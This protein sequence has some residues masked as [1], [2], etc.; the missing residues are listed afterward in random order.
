MCLSVIIGKKGYLY[1]LA[2]EKNNSFNY[3]FRDE[4][5]KITKY[6]L[7]EEPKLTKQNLYKY[8]EILKNGYIYIVSKS[9]NYINYALFDQEPKEYPEKYITILNESF[10]FGKLKF[11]EY[12][13]S[14]S[15]IINSNGNE[16]L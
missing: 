7:I 1:P 10:V 2:D 5:E 13:E 3:E 16:Y 6:I 14:V 11:D 8:K 12:Q 4:Q 9:G 15:I